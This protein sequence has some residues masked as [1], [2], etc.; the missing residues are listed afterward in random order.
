MGFEMMYELTQIAVVSYQDLTKNMVQYFSVSKHRKVSITSLF[1]VRQGYSESLREY[2]ERFNEE[3][4]K[5]FHLNQEMFVGAFQHGLK[6][7][8][9]NEFL[10]QKQ[11]RLLAE[12]NAI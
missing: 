10:A 4:I 2:L 1:S 12:K 3:T 9:F 8:Q 6:V 7:R 5:I 11:M